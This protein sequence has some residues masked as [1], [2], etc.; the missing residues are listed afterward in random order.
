[1]KFYYTWSPSDSIMDNLYIFPSISLRD[2]P[3]I[4]K[5]TP[6]LKI[7]CQMWRQTYYDVADKTMTSVLTDSAY[8]ITSI[9]A[10][11]I[12]FAAI[13][14]IMSVSIFITAAILYINKFIFPMLSRM[15]MNVNEDEGKSIRNLENLKVKK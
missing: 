13:P 11:P 8:V 2:I 10:H 7:I 1:M 3:I 9:T 14:A 6:I 15:D 12:R 4:N 5:L